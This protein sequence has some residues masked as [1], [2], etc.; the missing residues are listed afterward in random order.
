[1]PPTDAFSSAFY[2]EGVL[3]TTYISKGR[4]GFGNKGAIQDLGTPCLWV[5]VME[6]VRFKLRRG[7]RNRPLI[8]LLFFTP[9]SAALTAF[10]RPHF[11]SFY[12][13]W[14]TLV[15]LINFL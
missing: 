12:S 4:T 14:P 1:M 13:L 7:K 8:L 6:E 5:L 2:V 15:P 11:H 9:Q 3:H 10:L